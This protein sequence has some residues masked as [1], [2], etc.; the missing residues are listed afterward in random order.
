MKVYSYL[1]LGDPK[2]ADGYTVY[3]SEAERVILDGISFIKQG[4]HLHNE[5][6]GQWHDSRAAARQAAIDELRA[7]GRRVL[8]HADI[9][10]AK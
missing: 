7:I 2:T 8:D 3:I 1:L 6:P 10:A 9:E 5:P 4:R